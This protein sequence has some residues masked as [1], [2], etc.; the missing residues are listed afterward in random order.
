MHQQSSGHGGVVPGAMRS[1]VQRVKAERLDEIAELVSG[2]VWELGT[3]QPQ[4]IHRGRRHPVR[5]RPAHDVEIDPNL[6][7]DDE[8]RARK[9][10]FDDMA[11]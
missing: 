8:V 4:G 2:Q 1:P 6:M 10:E 3:G 9:G 11:S 5:E 7:P